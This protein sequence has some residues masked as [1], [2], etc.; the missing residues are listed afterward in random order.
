MDIFSLDLASKLR[1]H[2]E[3]NNHTIKL[4][5]DQ[6][7]PY[8]PI[9]SLRPVELKTLKAYIKTNLA[10]GFIRLSKLPAGASILFKQKLDGSF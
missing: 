2:T 6:H 8:R 4:V 9:Y 7:S 5:N 1:E 10:N 3:I